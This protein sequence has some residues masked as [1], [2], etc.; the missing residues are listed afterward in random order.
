MKVK[1]TGFIVTLCVALAFVIAGVVLFLIPV[2]KSPIS[3]SEKIAVVQV[4]GQYEWTGKIKNDTDKDFQL[5]RYNFSVTVKTNGGDNYYG[6]DYWFVDYN[7]K[8]TPVTLAPGE[9]YDLSTEDFMT[10]Y[11]R[12]PSKV[13]QVRI[14]VDGKDY[15]LIGSPAQNT[16]RAFGVICFVLAVVFVI[17]AISVLLNNKKQAQRYKAYDAVISALPG[18]GKLIGGFLYRK[19]DKK[20][21]AAKSALSALGGAISAIFLGAGFYKVYSSSNPKEF[22]LT[23]DALFV[24]DPKSANTALDTMTR[25]DGS[26]LPDPTVAVKKNLVTLTSADGEI[27]LSFNY[28]NSGIAADEL[29]AKLNALF[30]KRPAPADSPVF[31]GIENNAATATAEP[32]TPVAPA[33]AAPTAT[34]EPTESADGQDDTHTDSQ[35]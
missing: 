21:A 32:V 6:E 29:V 2:P 11:D 26:N 13:T 1:K 35:A 3:M 34:A 5:N 33:D 18:G 16:R 20:K 7:L 23:D 9:E 19:G 15:Y 10:D 30:S 17:C 8:P 14:N 24:N 12:V 22:I 31:D 28:K 4:G 25:L 27:V